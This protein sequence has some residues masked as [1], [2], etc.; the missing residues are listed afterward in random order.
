[1]AKCNMD[2]ERQAIMIYKG[3]PDLYQLVVR[4][5]IGLDALVGLGITY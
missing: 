5:D 3:Y 4:S 2:A 1:M